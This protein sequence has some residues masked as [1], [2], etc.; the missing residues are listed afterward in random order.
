MKILFADKF[1]DS[2]M[3]QLCQQGHE[4]VSQPDLD[5]NT[6]VEAIGDAEVLVVRSTRV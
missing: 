1:P 6:L 2:G 5:G 4:C 3:A